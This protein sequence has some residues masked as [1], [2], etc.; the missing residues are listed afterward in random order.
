M[1]DKI[2]KFLSDNVKKLGCSCVEDLTP[3]KCSGLLKNDMAAMLHVALTLLDTQNKLFK[4][5][6][7]STGELQGRL[8]TTQGSVI[9]LQEELLDSKERQLKSLQST[10]KLSVEDTVKQQFKSYSEAVKSQQS[11]SQT[12]TPEPITTVVQKIV[13]KEDRSRNLMI[14]GLQEGEDEKLSEKVTD[15]LQTIGEKP[16]F[17]ACR[18]GAKVVGGRARAVKVTFSCPA[19]ISQILRKARDLKDSEH[20]SSVFVSKDMTKEERNK[21]RQLIVKL[22]ELRKQQPKLKHYISGGKV[23]SVEL[24]ETTPPPSA[25]FTAL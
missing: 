12:L 3:A 1:P 2:D 13:V 17:D 6:I 15:L 4:G 25:V 18:I 7:R 9:K 24:G 21:Q 20:Y 23:L 11:E 5:F 10:V 16:R 19:I 14:F 8:I 22:K